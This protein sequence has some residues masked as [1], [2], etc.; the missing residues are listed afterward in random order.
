V[1]TTKEKCDRPY[2][3][4]NLKPHFELLAATFQQLWFCGA[5]Q[6]RVNLSCRIMHSRVS[7]ALFLSPLV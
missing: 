3:W 6:V 7:A 4:R 2:R 1:K 5:F